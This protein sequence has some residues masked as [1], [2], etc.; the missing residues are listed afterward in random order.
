[1]I[2]S[3]NDQ[4]YVVTVTSCIIEYRVSKIP[5]FNF[6]VLVQDTVHS[7]KPGSARKNYKLKD[8]KLTIKGYPP[9]LLSLPFCY[10]CIA[11]Q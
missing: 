4:I 2:F 9:T 5:A 1:M 6:P 11:I 10:V 7:S 8:S 3:E